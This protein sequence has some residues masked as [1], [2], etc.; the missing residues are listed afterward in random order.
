MD[1]RQVLF[2]FII[3]IN[4][5]LCFFETRF[6]CVALAVLKLT[7]HQA[8]L[9]PR[10]LPT[11]VSLVLGLKVCATTALLYVVLRIKPRVFCIFTKYSANYTKSQSLTM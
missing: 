8:G 11:F 6:L 7:L 9:E 2:L 1:Y 5:Y 3:I 10:D 4:Y